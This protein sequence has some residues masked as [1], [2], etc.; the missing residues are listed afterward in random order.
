MAKKFIYDVKN[1]KKILQEIE[2]I[3]FSIS[4]SAEIDM[5][6][7]KLASTDYQALKYAEGYFTEEEYASIREQR[8]SWRNRINELEN[9]EVKMWSL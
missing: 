4:P 1:K 2:E 6:K 3:K 7:E 8:Q 9:L 5:L